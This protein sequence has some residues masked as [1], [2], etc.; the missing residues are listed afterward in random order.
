MLIA[1]ISSPKSALTEGDV[2]NENCSDGFE[3]CASTSTSCWKCTSGCSRPVFS[4]SQRAARQGWC[5]TGARATSRAHSLSAGQRAAAAAC[6]SLLP[7]HPP[8]CCENRSAH[9]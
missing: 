2:E 4:L 9:I 7:R 5:A 8:G 1:R 3:P 6:C